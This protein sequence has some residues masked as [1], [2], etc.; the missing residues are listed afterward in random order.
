MVCR[1][2]FSKSMDTEYPAIPKTQAITVTT[3]SP[4]R[5]KHSPFKELLFPLG[6]LSA[7]ISA[8]C[9]SPF[10]FSSSAIYAFSGTDKK[11]RWK[12]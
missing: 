8:R 12:K 5:A 9:F 7:D 4:G 10:Q 2:R 1:F 6:I 11:T 3:R